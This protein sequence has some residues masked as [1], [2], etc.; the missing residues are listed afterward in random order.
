MKAYLFPGQGA[1][2]TGMGKALYNRSEKAKKLFETAEKLL[3]F[4]ITSVM[5]EGTY[6]ALQATNV[7]QLAIFL[8]SVILAAVTPDF[9]PDKVA[10]HSLGEFSALVAAKVLSFEAG[11]QLVAERAMAM[12]EACE[13]QPSTMMAVL[14]L[15]DEKVASL[16]KGMRGSVVPANYNC[17]GQVVVAGSVVDIAYAKGVMQN[18]G[19]KRIV[20]LNVNGAFHSPYMEIAKERLEKAIRQ[21]KFTQGIYPVYQNVNA[22]PTTSPKVIQDNLVTQ[23]TAPVQWSQTIRYM[24]R[25]GVTHFVECG[26]GQV[27]Q[28]LVKKI[29]PSVTVTGL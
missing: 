29:D 15:A 23:L 21:T 16:C 2:F 24:I 1:Q 27:L 7:A 13:A 11:L 6:E 20:L 14:G 18:A 19:A 28:G 17:P 5:F 8:H 9:K 12:Q 22:L 26:P 4:P 10:G 25:D 3:D